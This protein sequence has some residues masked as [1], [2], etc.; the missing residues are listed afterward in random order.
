[1]AIVT[2]GII[3]GE[4]SRTRK[5]CSCCGGLGTALLVNEI[6]MPEEVELDWTILVVRDSEGKPTGVPMNFLGIS[7]GCYAK[8][9]RQVAHI[10]TKRA[11]KLLP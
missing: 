4:V 3:T 6:E 11:S 1:M 7:C 10:K 9:H 8:F 5:R 2:D